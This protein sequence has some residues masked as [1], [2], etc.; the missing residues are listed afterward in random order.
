MTH[1]ISRRRF[2]SICGMAGAFAAMPM[3]HVLAANTVPL[4]RWNG[5]LMGAYVHLSITH[6][7][8]T[9]ADEIFELCVNEIKRLE[10]IFT[11]YDSHSEISKLNKNGKLE[12]PS[13]D[14]ID[15]LN[16]AKESHRLTDG[17]FDI[18]VKPLEEGSSTV[19]IGFE[20]LD[21]SKSEISFTKPDMQITLNGI[22]QGYITDR[23][24][25]LLKNLG[26]NNIL[27]ELGEKRSLGRHRIALPDH[28]IIIP[29]ENLAMATS[30][31]I[32]PD[33]DKPHIYNP[34]IMGENIR[35]KRI[36]SVIAET[37]TLADALS[38]GFILMTKEKTHKI[39]KLSPR[40]KH[41]Y[42]DDA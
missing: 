34:I 1:P 40:I 36:I 29:L 8:K 33:T 14:F 7:S 12:N 35:E 21:Y 23:I 26:L 28:N 10:N 19:P 4:H 42:Y 3:G 11:L 20:Y 24:T 15:L 18:T 13:P 2:I 30:S 27:V 17:A 22:A 31:A 16:H 38:T 39:A 6:P 41:V 5:I 37:A 25:E 9:R 32:S